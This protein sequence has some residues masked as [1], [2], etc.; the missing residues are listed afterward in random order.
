MTDTSSVMRS[1]SSPLLVL[2]MYET[3]RRIIFSLIFMRSL[4]LK[5]RDMTLLSRNVLSMENSAYPT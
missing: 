1:I 2:S 5:C 4:L 3:G